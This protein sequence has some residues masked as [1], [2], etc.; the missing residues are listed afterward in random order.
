MNKA[1]FSNIEQNSIKHVDQI[2][3]GAAVYI[4]FLVV[5]RKNDPRLHIMI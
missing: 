2:L 3:H 1:I 5:A 4:H